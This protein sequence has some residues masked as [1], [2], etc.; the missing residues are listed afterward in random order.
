MK[1]T[2]LSIL[3]IFIT[4]CSLFSQERIEN[5]PSFPLLKG[6]YLGQ[7]P[8]GTTPEIF[9][10]EIVSVKDRID[11]NSIFSSDY[12]KFY[13]SI[14]NN[15]RYEIMVMKCENHIWLTPKLC[16]F[17]FK[18]NNVDLF[19]SHDNDRIL[20]CSDRPKERSHSPFDRL[21]I[22]M[23]M[24]NT[25]GWSEPIYLGSKINDGE[26]QVY[27]SLSKHGNLYFSSERKDGFG[28]YDVYFSAFKDNTYYSP[29]N[30][31]PAI[32]SKNNEGDAFIS[33]DEKFLIV[34]CS[35][36]EDCIGGADL[37]ISFAN[38]DNTWGE[39]KNMGILINSED[40]EYCPVLTPD[41][42]YFMFSRR[43]SGNGDIY[44]VDSKVIEELKPKN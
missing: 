34:T 22:W 13:F 20:F 35:E 24:K 39:L 21:K 15:D 11:L 10:P 6:K 16:D 29:Q 8:P 30:L 12:R 44:W 23:M 9:A 37:Y 33:P 1:K 17:S 31:G 27:P 42:K 5:N 18:H 28:G 2:V 43:H 38:E 4:L 40:D 25:V 32:N 7:N 26:S 19:I 14:L 41:G 3:L 36:R